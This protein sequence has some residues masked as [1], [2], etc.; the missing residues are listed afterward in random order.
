M[1]IRPAR[2]DDKAAIA[3]FTTDTF[4]WGDY[5]ADAFDSWMADPD[6]QIL[7]AADSDDQA[8][9]MARVAMLSASEAWAQAARVHPDH[10]RQGIALQLTEAGERWAA[11]RGALVMRLV[12]EDWNE[13]AQR[14]VDK[15]GYRSV[16]RW[17]MGQRSIGSS[18]PNPGGN[19]G[20]RA[21][22][23]E[24]L[25]PA[26]VHEGEA[27]FLA[28]A[29]G[30]LTAAAHGLYPAIGWMWRQMTLDDVTEAARSRRLWDCPSGWVI[31][32]LHDDLFWVPWIS[33]GPDDVHRLLRAAIEL[34]EEQGA[35]RFRMLFPQTDW[36]E[37]ATR[38]AG[39]EVSKLLMYEKALA[40][41]PP[42]NN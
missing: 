16:A 22:A 27:A 23:A 26:P 38:R 12:T 40:Q 19:G 4:E 33:T 15:A 1:N 7:I 25:R 28:W 6:G 8:A 41:Q 24:R 3:A 13:P 11:E 9:G 29:T 37:Q 10:R 42:A 32:D 36:L 35:E 34:G 2:S 20:R 39:L 5:V 14:Q 18:V 21:P 30:D 17:A 31:G